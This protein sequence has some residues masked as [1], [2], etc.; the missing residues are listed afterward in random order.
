MFR[1]LFKSK[2]APLKPKAHSAPVISINGNHYVPLANKTVK[3]VVI[4]GKTYIPVKAAPSTAN[5]T[6]AIAPK[7]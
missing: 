6:N 1:P 4:D 3:P 2:P 7:T 5:K